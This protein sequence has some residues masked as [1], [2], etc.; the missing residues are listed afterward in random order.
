MRYVVREMPSAEWI[1]GGV[2]RS[3]FVYDKLLDQVVCDCGDA[4]DFGL[5]EQTLR[6]AEFICAA[7]QAWTD[8]DA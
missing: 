6:D 2:G 7:L 5:V 3:V 8:R 1:P 4:D